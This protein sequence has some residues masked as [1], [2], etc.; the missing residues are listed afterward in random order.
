LYE[1]GL[2]QCRVIQGEQHSKTLARMKNLAYCY[3]A[4]GRLDSAVLLESRL[5]EVRD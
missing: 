3:R 4:V 5:K 1:R 2:N